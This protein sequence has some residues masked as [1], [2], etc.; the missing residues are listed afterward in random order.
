[1][2]SSQ[3]VLYFH[4]TQKR[5]SIIPRDTQQS[6]KRRIVAAK[7]VSRKFELCTSHGEV[8]EEDDCW[9]IHQ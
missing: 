6:M 2:T 1:M 7:T 3:E 4:M 9:S 5:E 8:K